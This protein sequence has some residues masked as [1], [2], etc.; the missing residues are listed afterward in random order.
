VF[1][2]LTTK[3][4]DLMQQVNVRGTYLLT[5]AWLPALLL[6]T[7]CHDLFAATPGYGR[8]RPGWFAAGGITSARHTESSR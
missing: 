7:S 6:T 1:C 3:R 8:W 5:K 2:E 4:F